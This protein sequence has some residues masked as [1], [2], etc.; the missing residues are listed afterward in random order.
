[1]SPRSIDL[2]DQVE[3]LQWHANAIG[4]AETQQQLRKLA[5]Q[6]VARA[7]WRSKKS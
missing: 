5:A 3:N 4:D 6:Y 2:R 1:M 7:G